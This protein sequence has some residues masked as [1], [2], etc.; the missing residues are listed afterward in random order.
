MSRVPPTLLMLRQYCTETYFSE[1]KGVD[2]MYVSA[3]Q[4][5]MG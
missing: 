1:M 4:R 3:M 5:V 2:E